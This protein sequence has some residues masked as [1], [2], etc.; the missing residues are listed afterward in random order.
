MAKT[1]KK[2]VVLFSTTGSVDEAENISDYLIANHL[3][4]CVNIVPSIRSVYW[5]DNK[6][7]HDAEVLMIIKT[8][9]SKIEEVEKSIRRL[10]SYETPELIALPLHYGI[11]EYLQ[12]MTEALSPPNE[13]SSD[14]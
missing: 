5:W 2:F 13:T 9:A 11:A 3:A 1:N 4:A 10:H 6:V 14:R 7:N 12:W 8:A